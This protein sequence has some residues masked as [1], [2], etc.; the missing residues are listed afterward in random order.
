MELKVC[1]A[2]KE[3]KPLTD[4]YFRKETGRYRTACK[5]CKSVNTKE[6][7][8]AKANALIRIC[9]NC[10]IEK[11]S[12][13][14]Q[15]AGKYFQPYC[16]TCDSE[17]KKSWEHE[18]KERLTLHRRRYYIEKVKPLFVPKGRVLKS[19]EEKQKSR[20]RYRNLPEVKAKKS[21]ADKKYRENN[22]SKIKA[23]KKEYYDTKGLEQ[24]KAWQKKMSSNIEFNTKKRLRG[25]I[26]VAL[27]R[28][29]KSESTMN[30]L[31]CSIDQ[32]KEYFQSLFV[33][34][35]S[36]DKYMAGEIVIDHIKPCKLFNLSEPAQQKE[37]FNYKNLQPLWKLDNLRK[38]TFYSQEK[39]S[40]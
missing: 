22:Y 11:P 13:E 6:D 19:A 10:G 40:A 1:E 25:R 36:W 18:N 12:T 24:A 26:Y 4:F 28:G 34:G 27:K 3:E 39:L 20:V 32:F 31:G 7:I 33:D 2:C 5:K 14:F 35:M 21:S 9:K 17:R 30:L 8:L 16:K 23:R 15:K 38:G 37:C 29:I